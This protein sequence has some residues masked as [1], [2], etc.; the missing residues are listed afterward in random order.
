MGPSYFEG[1]FFRD[2]GLHPL[3]SCRVAHRLLRRPERPVD[4]KSSFPPQL[5]CQFLAREIAVSLGC[6]YSSCQT[7]DS[8]S[9]KRKN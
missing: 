9:E 7:I 2:V 8:L 6:I 1:A 4:W 3:W 5:F